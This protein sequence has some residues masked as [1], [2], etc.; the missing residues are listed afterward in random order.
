MFK[1]KKK[2]A[3]WIPDLLTEEQKRTR[4][5]MSCKLLDRLPRYDQ[6]KIVNLVTGRLDTF[7]Q[8]KKLVTEYGQLQMPQGRALLNNCKCEKDYVCHIFHYYRTSNPGPCIQRQ[9]NV[10]TI[11]L[12]RKGS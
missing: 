7:L 4:N 12:E 6:K 11:L 10:S 5:K 3:R 2:S 9:V 8:T 1:G